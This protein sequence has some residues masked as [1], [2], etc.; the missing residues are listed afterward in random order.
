VAVRATPHGDTMSIEPSWFPYRLENLKG[1]LEWKDGLLRFTGVRGRHDRTTVATDGVCRFLPDGGWHVSFTR[2]AADRFR[3][4]YDVLEAMP[5][6]LRRAVAAVHPRGLLS[7]DGTVDIYSTQPTAEGRPGP[8]AA[9]WDMQLDLEQASL[10]VG[11]PLD[12]VHGGVHLRGQSDGRNWRCE[13]DLKIDSAI[14]R[15]VQLTGIAGPLALDGSGVRFGSVANH[16]GESTPRRLAARV[17]GG[18]L[19]LDGNVAAG[20]GGGFAISASLADADLERIGADTFRGAA[21]GGRAYKGRVFGTLELTGSRAGT[22]SLAGRGQVRLRDADIYDLPVVL[23][24]LKVLR[25]KAPDLRAFGSSAVD[26]R[27]EG[28]RAYLDNIELS[29]DAISLVGSG[30]VEFDSS[31]HLTFRSIMGDSQSQLPAMKSMLGGASGN[32]LLIHVDGTLAAP[33][34][35]SEAFPTL[36]A[37]LQQWQAQAQRR[38][39]PAAPP[40][41]SAMT[42]P[43]GARQAGFE[44]PLP[45]PAPA[46]VPLVPVPTPAEGQGG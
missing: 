30:E 12:H 28:P 16:V 14:C 13:G 1:A 38:D 21:A 26:F 42:S 46:Q 23:A 11:A 43:S 40:P 35:T 39:A 37:A 2:L 10:D 7:V 33:K 9:S 27:V 20:D 6:G 8:A 34:I 22:H 45:P 17:A 29:G 36:A 44:A 3:A 19:L 15:G 31:V 41:P 32:F 5:A 24:M 25:V 4:E 18:T